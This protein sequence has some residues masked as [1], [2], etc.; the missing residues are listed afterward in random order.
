MNK[1][2][3]STTP[4]NWLDAI[5]SRPVTYKGRPHPRSGEPIDWDVRRFVSDKDVVLQPYVEEWLTDQ[6]R[7]GET[8]M[9]V[10]QQFAV[11]TISYIGDEDMDHPEFFLF[12]CEALS[13]GLGDC[14]EFANLIA[15]FGLVGGVP[16]DRLRVWCGM[17]KAGHGAA[18]GGHACCMFKR[19][20]DDEWVAVDGC[21]LADPEV[22]IAEKI[23][24]R[25]RAEY[26]YG[27]DTWFAYNHL[28]SWSPRISFAMNRMRSMDIGV[29]T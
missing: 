20:A 14:E 23:P 17:V 24:V 10:G 7:D 19:P 13:D 27:Q 6:E 12:V 22:P 25:F 3:P 21:Y 18:T 15:S 8:V 4:K 2:D 9:L 5:P 11:E 16:A 1:E 29:V 26:L 28:E